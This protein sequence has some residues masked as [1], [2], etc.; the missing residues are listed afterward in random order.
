MR[1]RTLLTCV[2]AGLLFGCSAPSGNAYTGVPRRHH[3][4][5]RLQLAIDRAHAQPRRWR[6]GIDPVD[7]PG[8]AVWLAESH[9]ATAR[10]LGGELSALFDG[11]VRGTGAF[12]VLPDDGSEPG[13]HN[14]A[15]G[16]EMYLSLRVLDL[17]LGGSDPADP[18]AYT[19]TLGLKV[20]DLRTGTVVFDSES[21][22]YVRRGNPLRFAGTLSDDPALLAASRVPMEHLFIEL[23]DRV[24]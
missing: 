9:G 8:D 17:K 13:S 23:I 15:G 2:L 20:R 11:F 14:A 21:K 7:A 16:A 22:G 4:D 1:L 18:N 24:Y 19:L 12:V 5:Q 10:S 3:S 6:V